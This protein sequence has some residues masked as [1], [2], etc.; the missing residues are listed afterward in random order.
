MSKKLV[1]SKNFQENREATIQHEK[2]QVKEDQVE[3]AINLIKAFQA[4][5]KP[6]KT[7]SFYYKIYKDKKFLLN[8]WKK[9]LK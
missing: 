6:M 1:K 4:L 5:N 2:K 7:Y 3:L 8:D 9:L